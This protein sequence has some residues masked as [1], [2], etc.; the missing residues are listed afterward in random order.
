MVLCEDCFYGKRTHYSYKIS[1]EKNICFR[2]YSGFD[3]FQDLSLQ[4]KHAAKVAH[5]LHL[6]GVIACFSLSNVSNKRQQPYRQF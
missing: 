2:L 6:D 3:F 4:G 1:V 5:K